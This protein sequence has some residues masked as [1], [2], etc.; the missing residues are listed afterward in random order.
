LKRY[1]RLDG[2]IQLDI[3]PIFVVIRWYD[4]WVSTC[5]QPPLLCRVLTGTHSFFAGTLLVESM[6]RTLGCFRI[7]RDHRSFF[8]FFPVF[9]RKKVSAEDFGHSDSQARFLVL[10]IASTIHASYFILMGSRSGYPVMFLAYVLSAFCRA[11][12]TGEG[13]C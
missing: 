1:S 11:L 8:P 3:H 6:M 9:M 5:T 13:K 7:H 10:V 2:P 4:V 12:L